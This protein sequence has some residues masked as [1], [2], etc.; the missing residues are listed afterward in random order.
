LF[1]SI[2]TFISKAKE[3]SIAMYKSKNANEGKYNPTLTCAY[4]KRDTS[5][6][7]KKTFSKMAY[8]TIYERAI[9]INQQQCS[10]G[11]VACMGK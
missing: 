8:N 10:L 9:V 4:K 2:Q 7:L 6:T 11:I 5:H 1:N 3:F